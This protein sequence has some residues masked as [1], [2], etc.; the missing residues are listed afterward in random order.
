MKD[1]E[2][3]EIVKEEVKMTEEENEK[4]MAEIERLEDYYLNI[5]RDESWLDYNSRVIRQ[6]I[7]TGEH[8]L[9]KANALQFIGIASHNLDEFISVRF[10]DM[11]DR[12]IM[13]KDKRKFLDRIRLQRASIL[14][15]YR[16]QFQQKDYHKNFSKN[17]KIK[18][19][20]YKNILPVLTP[21][22]VASNKEIP[23]LNE[24][25]INFFIKLKKTET[26]PSALCFLQIPFQLKRLYKYNDDKN[27]ILI[28][29]I[30]QEF[31]KDIFNT[32][33]ISS[34][35]LFRVIK[36]FNKEIVHDKKES[37]VS[38]VNDVLIKRESNDIVFIDAKIMDG[39]AGK[40][41]NTLRKLLKVNKENIEMYCETSDVI[42]LHYVNKDVIKDVFDI[43]PQVLEQKYPEELVGHSSIMDYLDED[44]LLLH[45]PFDT[46]DVTIQ[47]LKEAVNDAKTLSIKQTLY[48]VT[49]SKSPVV[50]LLCEAATK[51]IQVTVMLELLA[52]FDE[53]NN[54]S[55]INVLK[56]S[57]VNIVYSLENYKTHCKML[58]ITK[59]SKKGIKL[60]S[61]VSTGNYNEE[62][63]KLYT[64][65]SYFTSR[66]KIGM[67]LNSIFNMITGFSVPD[68]FNTVSCSP[69][70]L[71][72][73]IKD[74]INTLVETTSEERPSTV[75]IKVNSLNDPQ[76]V[77]LI[78]ETAKNN[79]TIEFNIIC[80]GICTLKP[81]KNIKIKSIV[82]RFLE[83]SRM[84]AFIQ[85]GKKS[86]VFISSADLLTR[87]LFKRIEVMVPVL[88]RDISRRLVSIF[89][90]YWDD[91]LDTWWLKE[92]GTWEK[93]EIKENDLNISAQSEFCK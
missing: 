79:P 84:Y 50:K 91:V 48:R 68:K 32:R 80:R 7:R 12:Q 4:G 38:R 40:L 6:I 89:S 27:F 85:K 45:H 35:V 34:F 51:G 69:Y 11:E 59:E 63:S 75:L 15:L 87:N 8:D 52:R 1:C 86:K 53:R 83:H 20:F 65:F 36:K 81:T 72:N 9:T 16:D 39:K 17:K 46:F 26:E 73:R 3:E 41:L 67:D 55:L 37:I 90:V 43:E 42:G 18:E 21:I 93:A 82:G 33:E 49:S 19:I 13:K 54:I 61:H 92:D 47:F 66:T 71:F 31:L 56:N 60:Y 30:V 10:S 25:D 5:K 29:D 14:T 77:E 57:G 62:T 70:G 74:E 58:L 24:N 28:E 88:D 78:T 64:D 22:L 44:D 76:I 23:R 2:N